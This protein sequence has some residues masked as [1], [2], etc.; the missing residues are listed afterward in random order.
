MH[1]GVVAERPE[2]RAP[3]VDSSPRGFRPDTQA[4][5]VTDPG[6]LMITGRIAWRRPFVQGDSIGAVVV[7]RHE[8]FI[9]QEEHKPG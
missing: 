4:D 7:E 5:E 1:D 8:L 9:L 3:L 2:G 6:A